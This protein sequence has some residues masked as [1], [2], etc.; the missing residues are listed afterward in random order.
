M[1]IHRKYTVFTQIIPPPCRCNDIAVTVHIA[2]IEVDIHGGAD[3][4]TVEKTYCE[5]C[6][7]VERLHWSR[8]GVHRLRLYRFMSRN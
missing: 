4:V 8:Q 5:S 1:L 2:G 3:V 7:H 6:N